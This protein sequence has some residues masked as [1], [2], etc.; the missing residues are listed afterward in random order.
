ME[1]TNG[2]KKK[3]K[4]ESNGRY[5]NGYKKKVNR[6]RCGNKNGRRKIEKKVKRKKK[7]WKIVGVYLNGGIEKILERLKKWMEKKEERIKSLIEGNFNARTEEK[8]KE[9]EKLK[10]EKIDQE[11]RR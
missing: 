7:K 11:I 10:Q 4:K 2:K 5:D 3:Q 1:K 9:E 8:E 6:Q